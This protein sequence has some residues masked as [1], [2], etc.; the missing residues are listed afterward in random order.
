MNARPTT[1]VGR[2]AQDTE[3]WSLDK[4]DSWFAAAGPELYRP[5]LTCLYPTLCRKL[6]ATALAWS[7]PIHLF[8]RRFPII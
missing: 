6:P 1:F 8:P 5:T 4:L 3:I 7:R 2:F